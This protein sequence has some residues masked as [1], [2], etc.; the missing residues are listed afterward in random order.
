[1]SDGTHDI[2]RVLSKIRKLQALSESPN[3]NEAASAAAKIQDMLFQHNLTLADV[4]GEDTDSR[5]YIM[6]PYNLMQVASLDTNMVWRRQMLNSIAQFNFCRTIISHKTKARKGA[7][8]EAVCIIGRKE[9]IEVVEYLYEYLVS[10][11]YR[12]GEIEW[13]TRGFISSRVPR[14]QYLNSF[15]MGCVSA[16]HHTLSARHKTQADATVG[17]TALVRQVEVELD[18]AV[19][20][21]FNNVTSGKR[22]KITDARAFN[23]GYEV[24]GSIRISDALADEAYNKANGLIPA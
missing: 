16:V 5:K 23:S 2:D 18:T 12:L 6:E 21:F 10:E 9:N 3:A 24:G 14:K 17:S 4:P 7:V 13:N 15:Y 1:M 11:I 8:N 22:V 19:N 20:E